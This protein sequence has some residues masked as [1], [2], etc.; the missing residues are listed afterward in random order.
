MSSGCGSADVLEALGAK[1][2]LTPH[3]VV[4]CIEETGFG[5]MFAQAFHPAM[6]YAAPTR[7]EIGVRT[8][9]NILG[10]LT[11][12]ARAESQVLGVA[13]PELA[14]LM[15]AALQRLGSRHVLVVHGDDG[16]DELVLD[17]VNIVYELRDGKTDD[18]TISAEDVGLNQALSAQ[19]RGGSPA[20]NAET[21]NSLFSGKKGPIRE[22]VL[23]NAAAAL[24]AA[25]LA[26]DLRQA[27]PLASQSLDSGE[28]KRRL[29]AFV[30]LS[31]SFG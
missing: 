6:K 20:E 30:D 1:I 25:D 17:G 14:P 28:A 12:P 7:R 23:F 10:P 5:F 31:Q 18:Y 24:V 4:Q 11:N 21:M 22:V 26:P 27:V 19:I 16:S 3:Q 8:A 15:T 9:F 29:D 13:M 2:D